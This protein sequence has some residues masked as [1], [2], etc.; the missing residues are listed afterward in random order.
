MAPPPDKKQQKSKATPAKTT[1][2]APASGSAGEQRRAATTGAKRPA[3]EADVATFMRDLDHPLKED[4]E[5][6]RRVILGLKVDGP[7]QIHE[8]IKWNAPS[9]RTTESDYFATIFLRDHDA[10]RLILH[11]GA[12]GKA[13]GKAIALSE[14]SDIVKWLAKDRCMVCL[15]AGKDLRKKR[16]KLESLVSEWLEQL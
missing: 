11:T 7:D 16:A 9:F 15:G 5:F 4:I 6:V 13:G 3:A 8:A 1:R 12:K 2:K 10:V 14:S